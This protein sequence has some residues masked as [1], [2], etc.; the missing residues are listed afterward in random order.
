M[1]E[2]DRDCR[3]RAVSDAESYVDSLID[4]WIRKDIADTLR[5]PAKPSKPSAPEPIIGK[6][7]RFD[8][9]SLRE[10]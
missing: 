2:Y 1:I 7:E 3:E 6:V 10:D 8:P 4:Q 5:F 9:D